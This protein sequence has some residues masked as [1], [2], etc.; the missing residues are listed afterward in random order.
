MPPVPNPTASDNA[1][2]QGLEQAVRLGL[3]RSIGVSNYNSTELAALRGTVPAVNQ[4]QMSVVRE[5]K[6]RR[7]E[8]CFVRVCVGLG[9][10]T[11]PLLFYMSS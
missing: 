11:M 4:C 8:P 10:F 1:L 5:G 7:C 2:W 6:L 3:T 9:A